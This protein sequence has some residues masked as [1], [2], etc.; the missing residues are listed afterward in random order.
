MLFKKT[1]SLIG[2]SVER[3]GPFKEEDQSDVTFCRIYITSA[4][5]D[6]LKSHPFY[7]VELDMKGN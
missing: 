7:K 6:L 1:N 3:T 2:H 5:K 4:M